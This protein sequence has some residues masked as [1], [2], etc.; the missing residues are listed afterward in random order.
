MIQFSD[1]EIAGR[2]LVLDNKSELYYLG[3]NLTPRDCTIALR[4]ATRAL[5]I[6]KVNFINCII[7]VKQELRNFSWTHASLVGCRF[8]GR[9]LGSDFG[10][11][12]G[13]SPWEH[14]HRQQLEASQRRVAGDLRPHHHRRHTP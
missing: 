4:V 11:W 8:K 7:D 5:V 12:R 1:Q 10:Y 3:H 14:A 13:G 9:M 2:S 6:A